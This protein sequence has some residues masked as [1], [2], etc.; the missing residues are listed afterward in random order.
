MTENRSKSIEN[1]QE[2]WGKTIEI[3]KNW[4]RPFRMEG[5][6]KKHQQN[7]SPEPLL[8]KEASPAVLAGGENSG[9]ALEPEMP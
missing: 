7:S 5:G 6:A 3:A 4:L 8:K 2:F 9:G 1:R